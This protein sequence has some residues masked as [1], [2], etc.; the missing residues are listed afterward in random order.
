M[1]KRIK[2]GRDG[3]VLPLCAVGGYVLSGTLLCA[4]GMRDVDSL[5]RGPMMIAAV[6]VFLAG[7]TAHILDRINI[8]VRNVWNTAERA[9]DRRRA[10]EA[11]TPPPESAAVHQLV[12]RR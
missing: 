4:G 11:T 9:G 10:L 2:L 5:L 1:A 8:S 3:P 12:P 7:A 6:I